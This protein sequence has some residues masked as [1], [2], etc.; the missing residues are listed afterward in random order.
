M[1]KVSICIPT[2]NRVHLLPLAV[3][4]VLE[5]TDPDWELIICDDGST[6]GTAQLIQKYDHTRIKYIRHVHNIGKSN[7]M[8]SG[9]AAATGEYFLKFDDEDRLTP[10][11]L[12]RTIPILAANPEV[13]FVGTDHWIINSEGM[14]DEK[15]TALNSLKWGRKSLVE[16]VVDNLLEVVFV[17]Q[18]F[19][20]GATLFRRKTLA[21]V[22]FMRPDWQNCED[23]DLFVR[24]ALAG[25]TG[26]YLPALLMEYRFHTE[27]VGID[28]AIPYLQDKLRYLESFQFDTNLEKVRQ[29]RLADTQQV[30]GLRLIENGHTLQGRELV[31][32][33][34]VVL[35]NSPKAT[36]GLI[37]SYLPLSWR[38]LAWKLLRQSRFQD[39]SQKVRETV[40]SW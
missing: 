38:Q 28:R 35:G 16:G 10:E 14:R 4:S 25:K 19:Q 31:Q 32:L 37:L 34:T 20:I 15:A 21:E 13:D 5:Q 8:G 3:E 11:F 17:K 18:S 36:L 12:A 33:S 30:L 26:Y 6:H 23:N 39:Y 7:N 22:G 2:Y 24:L 27:Q 40:T 29:Q 9:F 1:T